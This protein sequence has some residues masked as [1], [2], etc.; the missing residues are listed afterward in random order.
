MHTLLRLHQL[1][2]GSRLL[3][4]LYDMAV[5]RGRTVPGGKEGQLA[6]LHL[7]D[8]GQIT[9]KGLGLA[10]IVHYGLVAERLAAVILGHEFVLRSLSPFQMAMSTQSGVKQLLFCR[11]TNELAANMFS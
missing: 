8:I 11:D 4:K 3:G 9:G 5:G 6:V 7:G 1:P 2:V 10:V